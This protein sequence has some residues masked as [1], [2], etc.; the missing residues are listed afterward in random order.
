MALDAYSRMGYGP[1]YMGQVTDSPPKAVRIPS[2]VSGDDEQHPREQGLKPGK[3]A[4]LSAK[5]RLPMSNIQENK[6]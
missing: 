1:L 3:Q 2:P 6:D 4:G 5:D